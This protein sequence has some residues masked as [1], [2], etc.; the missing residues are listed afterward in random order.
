MPLSV[1]DVRSYLIDQCRAHI[2]NKGV[3][4]S[5]DPT[6]TDLD[7]SIWDGLSR[8]GIY[9]DELRLIEDADLEQVT[10]PE[11]PLFLQ[12]CVIA[13][14]NRVLSFYRSQV[15]QGALGT[16]AE[17][18]ARANGL[19]DDIDTDEEKYHRLATQLTSD[20]VNGGP[21]FSETRIPDLSWTRSRA[22]S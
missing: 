6:A 19:A 15:T 10:P 21:L 9:L 4:Y 11:T 13:L 16:R 2:T 12:G 3:N 20:A 17:F 8:H 14:K 5:V 18:I 22:S 1:I 7:P